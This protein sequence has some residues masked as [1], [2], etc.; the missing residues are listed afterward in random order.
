[1]PL[2]QYGD[3]GYLSW[4]LGIG[5]V[6]P[7]WLAGSV[8]L[9]AF[10]PDS[11][12]PAAYVRLVSVAAVAL[13]ALLL[14]AREAGRLRTWCVIFA[15]LMLMFSTGYDEYY[16]FVVGPL[17]A[18]LWLVDRP[19]EAIRPVTFGLC[20]ALLAAWYIP[21]AAAGAVVGLAY[22]AQRPARAALAGVV[23]VGAY[24]ALI[25]L[26]WSGGPVAYAVAL[27]GD[28][29][30]GSVNT[31]FAR[32]VGQELPGTI[33]FRPS[34]LFAPERLADLAYMALW[35]GVVLSFLLPLALLICWWRPGW[36]NWLMTAL[37][38][39][40]GVYAFLVVP[41]LGPRQDIDLFACG[42]ICLA[43]SVG[44]ALDR[45]IAERATRERWRP[46]IVAWVTFW[47]GWGWWMLRVVG[48]P[49]VA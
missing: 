3:A 38:I 28:L 36:P 29:N 23:A 25:A 44:G 11:L 31:A 16:P 18:L 33:I 21:L 48:L 27:G 6:P 46:W 24:L 40:Q 2:H 10:R 8:L 26:L 35:S 32:Y 41:K 12:H 4:S 13:P 42:A 37:L 39:Q 30:L 14:A 49:P 47:G 43:W 15:P 19:V 5:H 9:A 22:L 45:R 7:R 34:Y 1:L 20:L 17:L